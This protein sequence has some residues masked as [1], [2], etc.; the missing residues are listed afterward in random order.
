MG[1]SGLLFVA[2]LVATV[3]AGAC[4]A[5][6]QRVEVGELQTRSRSV[7][8]QDAESARATLRLAVGKLDVGGGAG[9]SR[10]M[11]ADF[12]YNV[13]AWE[14]A[15]DYDVVGDS[16]ELNVRQQGLTEGIP[17]QDVR[18]AWD[19]RL[20][21]K[22]PLDLT[23]QVGG[24][25][26]NLDLDNLALTK[27]NLDVGAGSTRVDLSGD[28]KR[29]VSAVVRGGAGEITMLLPSQMG[30]K[31]TAGTRLGRIN[32]EGLQKDGKAYV[33]DAY[34]KADNTLNVDITGGVGQFNLQTVQGGTPQQGAAVQQESTQQQEGTTPQPEST[35]QRG[36]TTMMREGTEA[37]APEGGATTMDGGTTTMQEAA[38]GLSAILDDPQRYYGQTTTVSGPVGQVIEPRAFVMVDEQ[39][40]RGG[41]PSEVELAEGGVLVVRTGGPPPDV[42][43]LQSVRTTGTPQAFDIASFEQQQG[44]D[45]DEALYS[46]YED[47]PV[48]VAADVEATGGEGTTP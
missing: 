23:V 5:A 9:G 29:D 42:A 17:T 12:S 20:S 44:V 6:P 19:V 27:L 24:G 43:E 1:R 46:E 38:T 11:E 15:V 30:A 35:R 28:W 32:A 33:N 22:V 18:N 14:P 34:G 39:A 7:E 48:L 41:A 10:L 21:E 13:A 26:G 40:V 45:L 3:L 2:V 47:R 16:G 4:G 37:T 36:G 8:A 25:V 31:V